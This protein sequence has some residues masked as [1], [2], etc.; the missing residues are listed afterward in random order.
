LQQLVVTPV[1]FKDP[2]RTAQLTQSL[3]YKNQSVNRVYRNNRCLFPDPH[4][5]HKYSVRTAQI[6]QSLGYKNQSVNGVYRNN[7]CLL[8]DPH[9]TH[10]YPVL[11]AQ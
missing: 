3:G 6:T 5:T 4:K 8:P 2:V 1:M 9:K 10:K 11:T 7:R